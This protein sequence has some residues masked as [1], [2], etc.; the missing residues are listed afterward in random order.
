MARQCTA[1]THPKTE[2]LSLELIQGETIRG[3]ARKYKLSTS[4]VARHKKHLPHELLQSSTAQALVQAGSVMQRVQELE[5]RADRIYHEAM[6]NKKQ[7]LALRALKEMREVTS[8]YAKL[9]GE[10]ETQTIHQH[11]HISPEWLSLRSVMLNA[12]L[13][14]PDARE[15]LIQAIERESGGVV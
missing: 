14:Y 4:A 2:A 1:C 15:A 7:E 6:A 12:L 9:A 10:L 3:V 8:L 11:V 13:P 5:S